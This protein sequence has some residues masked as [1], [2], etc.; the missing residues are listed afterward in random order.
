M[1]F[2]YFY[3][4]PILTGILI[5]A[6]YMPFPPWAVFFC[7]I[8]LWNFALQQK[9]L[10]PILIGGWLCQVIITI[11]GGGW[12]AYA[13][14]EF[15]DFSW[16]SSILI[17]MVFAIG[18]NLQIP[19]ALAL[20]FICQKKLK[21]LRTPHISPLFTYMLLPTIF[22]LCLLYYPTIFKW[23]LGYTWFYANWPAAQTAEIWGFQFINT[24][25]LFSNLLFLVAFKKPLSLKTTAKPILVWTL[26]FATLNLWGT[27]L[28][29]RWPKPTHTAKVL[30]AQPN[31]KHISVEEKKNEN[32]F[33]GIK[34]LKLLQE[35]KQY[36]SSSSHIDFILWPEGSFMF[37]LNADLYYTSNNYPL[38]QHIRS[39]NT[40]ILITAPRDI[41]GNITNSIFSFNK[42]GELIQKPYNKIRLM[43]FGEY[44][45]FKWIPYSSKL[46]SKMNIHFPHRSKGFI[47]GSGKF[48]VASL[49]KIIIGFFIC[50]EGLFEKLSRNLANKGAYILLN[51]SNDRW[52]GKWQQPHQ[53]FYVTLSRAIEVR[54]PVLRGTN[55]GFSGLVTAKGDIMYKSHLWKSQYWIQSIPYNPQAPST[56]YS[57][58]GYYINQMFLWVIVLTSLLYGIKIRSINLIK[59]KN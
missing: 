36:L 30:M 52:F 55:S 29:H 22:S 12:M 42:L 28:K 43:A 11:C 37:R 27:Y 1:S 47:H 25:I 17:Y 40:P 4:W 20:W 44:W 10:K 38:Q 9:T 32:Y 53:H 16:I 35:T 33:L 8:P 41:E 48:T 58:W 51:T 6:S 15:G 21:Q 46:F 54:R 3:K 19:I 57:S 39:L 14:K 7:F 26:L 31:I 23:H 5:P 24:L 59:K 2:F 50:Y 34:F 45:P 49:N 13:I 56:I 18:A